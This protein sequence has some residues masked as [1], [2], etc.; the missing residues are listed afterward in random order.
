M[1]S[2]TASH[3]R[4]VDLEIPDYKRVSIAG[5]VVFGLFHFEVI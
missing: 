4:N 2:I 3:I 1:S 5:A